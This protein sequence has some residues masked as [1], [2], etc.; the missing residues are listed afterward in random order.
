[1]SSRFKYIV[2]TLSS[3]LVT[4]MLVGAVLGQSTPSPSSDP[5]RHIDVYTE[6]FA[7]IK[8]DYVEEPDMNSVT[9]G[10]INGLLVSID[11]FASY[12][13]ADQYKQYKKV[14]E[15]PKAGV[16]LILSRKY[17]Y[18]IGIVD[19]IPASPADK[20]GLATGDIIEAINGIST[21]DMP[22]AFADVLLHGEPG[23]TV[24]LTVL[25][26]RRPEPVKITMTRTNLKP[27]AP[28]SKMLDGQVG[29]IQVN[30][31]GPGRV[32]ELAGM[33]QALEKQ[34]MKK[35]VLDLRHCA[36]SAPE[37]GI[38]LANLF[39]AKGT[40]G[41][42]AGQ[43]FPKQTFDADP[44]K[45]IYR[46]PLAVLT[47]RGTTGAAEIAAA[48]LLDSKR[49]EIVGERTYGDAAIRK[50]VATEDGGAVLLAVAKYYSPSGKAIQDNSVTPVY[51]V[52]DMEPDSGEEQDRSTE[53]PARP[54]EDLILK[55]ALEVLSGNVQKAE[56]RPAYFTLGDA[57]GPPPV[58]RP[59]P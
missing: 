4:L 58:P 39:I 54:Q 40:L 29:Y 46:G 53:Q 56:S 28:A 26:L 19:A 13:S 18:E 32:K 49:A 22:L 36:T 31:L 50:A 7:K 42:V 10:A 14:L 17:G 30:D 51:P 16:G 25:R 27:P 9:L 5:Y 47:N 1:M 37:E 6:V 11:P 59:N 15:N 3:I 20:A 44:S 43:K 33:V 21:R 23:S 35:L 34:G 55:K 8:S 45:V 52:L 2:V 41:W 57:P 24:E 38:A 48:A 12:L